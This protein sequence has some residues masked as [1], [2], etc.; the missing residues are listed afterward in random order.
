MSARSPNTT[1]RPVGRRD[2]GNKS[3]RRGDHIV[4]R[5]S[6]EAPREPSPDTERLLRDSELYGECISRA[7]VALLIETMT[8][9][10]ILILLTVL[11]WR[12][13]PSNNNNVHAEYKAARIAAAAAACCYH[14][15]GAMKL[16]SQ[17]NVGIVKANFVA[18]G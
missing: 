2:I 17:K 16:V 14:G 12:I 5:N 9:P 7:T 1:V 18:I 10:L 3:S 4:D 6:K 8:T 15:N 11:C 13:W